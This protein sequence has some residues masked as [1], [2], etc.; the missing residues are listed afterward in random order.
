MLLDGGS[1]K[2]I[3]TSTGS[4]ATGLVVH[5]NYVYWLQNGN[6]GVFKVGTNGV[7][8][9]QLYADG[10]VS[11]GGLWTL[12]IDSDYLYWGDPAGG[13]SLMQIDFDGGSPTVLATGQGTFQG[14]DQYLGILY[15]ADD[16]ASGQVAS[17]VIA[18]AGLGPV[19]PNQAN[20]C[21][22]A[23][24]QDHVYW[25][26]QS[27]GTLLTALGG[28]AVTTLA[29]GLTN[30]QSLTVDAN[31]LYWTQSDGTVMQLTPR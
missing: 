27:A 2:T 29:T 30:A 4:Q 17:Y 11:P 15:W 16:V 19:V 1:P 5:Y 24:F 25:L 28:G 14:L 10:P 31:S 23:V 9:S 8:L 7:T 22:T 26:D 21:S 18:D 3:A 13:G 12:A 20:P 6:A